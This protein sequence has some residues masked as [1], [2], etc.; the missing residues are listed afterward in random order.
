M[1]THQL[2][3]D[4]HQ[5]G[6]QLFELIYGMNEL[7]MSDSM[8]GSAKR[9]TNFLNLERSRLAHNFGFITEEGFKTSSVKAPKQLLRMYLFGVG[10]KG[11]KSTR[12]VGTLMGAMSLI[13]GFVTSMYYLTS[14]SY[15]FLTGPHSEIKLAE[16]FEEIVYSKNDQKED[17]LKEIL[18]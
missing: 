17:E 9:T 2:S 14:Y 5:S 8:M 7:T 3:L 12:I 18:E 6:T 13:G 10:S 1:D 4:N 11:T 15:M 16:R